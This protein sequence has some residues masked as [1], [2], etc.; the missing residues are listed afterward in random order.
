MSSVRQNPEPA[1]QLHLGTLRFNLRQLVRAPGN[2]PR[3][4]AKYVAGHR[5]MMDSA[6]QKL[7]LKKI[8]MDCLKVMISMQIGQRLKGSQRVHCKGA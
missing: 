3:N 1:E 6:G 5:F 8:G 7:F 4:R 2:L